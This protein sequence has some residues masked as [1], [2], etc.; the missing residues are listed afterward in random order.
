MLNLQFILAC[1]LFLLVFFSPYVRADDKLT[2]STGATYITGDYGSS[3]PTEIYFVPFTFKYKIKKIQFKLLI[4]Y[5]EKTGPENVLLDVGQVRQRVSTTRTTESGLG[6]ITASMRYDLYFN[7]KY[8]IFINTQGKVKFGTADENKGLGNGKTDYSFNMGFFKI[9]NALTP[10]AKV[11]YKVYG[12]RDFNDVIFAS[13]GM[14][15][16]INATISSGLIY[17]Y[18]QKVTD[19]GVDKQQITGFS[20]QKLTKNW[21]L[22]EYIIKG[23]G[24]S[25]ADWGGGLSISYKFL[26]DH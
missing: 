23:F 3:V 18:R 14:T 7:P 12:R 26:L 10:F 11:G 17:S 9:F 6:D 22:Q 1:F 24:R 2:F 8:K 16:K 15:Y 21:S 4:P 13:A 25:T 5:L 20:S 19:S